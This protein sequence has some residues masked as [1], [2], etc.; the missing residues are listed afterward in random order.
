MAAL[1]LDA[2]ADD[3]DGATTEE[4]MLCAA[5]DDDDNGMTALEEPMADVA[6]PL[7]G[8]LLARLVFAAE[9]EV[10]P[11]LAALLPTSMELP[12]DATTPLDEPFP[13]VETTRHSPS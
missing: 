2:S 8:A 9:L 11:L 7:E 3:D 10:I 12:P 6:A 1:L 5:G 13:G 4:D